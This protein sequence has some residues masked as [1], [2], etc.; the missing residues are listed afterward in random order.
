MDKILLKQFL[1]EY[2]QVNRG[3]MC[4]V[5]EVIKTVEMRNLLD[6]MRNKVQSFLLET[7]EKEFKEG[8]LYYFERD[9]KIVDKEI[10]IK[11]LN[12]LIDGL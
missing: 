9:D 3:G 7:C 12:W 8:N 5:L 1:I 11:F 4:R 10:R 2:E 6:S